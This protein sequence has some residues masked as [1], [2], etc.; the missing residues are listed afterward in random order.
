ML[1]FAN[2]KAMIGIRARRLGITALSGYAQRAMCRC[3]NVQMIHRA[4]RLGLVRLN[5]ERRGKRRRQPGSLV[6]INEVRT[7]LRRRVAGLV[8]DELRKTRGRI[9]PETECNFF[10]RRIFKHQ[11]TLCFE[12]HTVVND[13][14]GT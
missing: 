12:Q 7:Q 3:V 5:A 11:R 8:L 13:L 14:Q 4:R 1:N 9:E 6:Y 2:E 10:V